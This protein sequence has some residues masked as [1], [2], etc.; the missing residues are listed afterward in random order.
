MGSKRSRPGKQL[1]VKIPA[2]SSATELIEAS[3]KVA[4]FLRVR[5]VRVV[6]DRENAGLAA[7]TIVRRDPLSG[8][9]AIAWPHLNAARLSLR[10]PIPLGHDEAGR[11]VQASLLWRNMLIGGEPGAG[12]SVLLSMLVATAALDP[13]VRLTLLDGKLVEL[14]VWARCAHRSVGVSATD[15]IEVLREL[16]AEMEHR[17]ARRP[18]V[19]RCALGARPGDAGGRGPRGRLRRAVE[20]LRRSARAAVMHGAGQ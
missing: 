3:E 9:P 4:A 11:W 8:G 6:R 19:P 12:K 10:D 18:G 5:E 7:V 17:A 2:G 16:Q 13:R 14:A 15:A 1:K 20:E